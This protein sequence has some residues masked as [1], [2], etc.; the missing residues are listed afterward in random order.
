MTA[1]SPLSQEQVEVSI[2]EAT[3]L[4]QIGRYTQAVES[5]QRIQQVLQD[6]DF[7]G[8]VVPDVLQTIRDLLSEARSARAALIEQAREYLDAKHQTES[9][10]LA[11]L[12]LSEAND[13]LNRWKQ[14][15]VNEENQVPDEPGNL[16]PIYQA[17]LQRLEMRQH[18]QKIYE[19]VR[20][21][22]ESEWQ[23]AERLSQLE[24]ANVATSVLLEYYV[25]A[26]GYARD[27]A[28]K[29]PDNPL[30]GALA[31]K[32]EAHY[33]LIGRQEEAMTTA[34]MAHEFEKT[35]EYIEKVRDQ[36][37]WIQVFDVRGESQGRMPAERAYEYVTQQAREF[38]HQK[39]DEYLEEAKRHLADYAPREA[40]RILQQRSKFD[41][42]MTSDDRELLNQLESDVRKKVQ[43]LE[44]AEEV[45]ETAR[46]L[47]NTQDALA[48]WSKLHES[49]SQYEGAHALDRFQTVRE[50]ILQQA[51]RE[52][53][54]GQDDV[55]SLFERGRLADA[56]SRAAQLIARYKDVDLSLLKHVKALEVLKQ[57]VDERVSTKQAIHARL[58]AISQEAVSD[59]R[60]ASKQLE[61]LLHEHAESGLVPE[62]E[63]YADVQS[64][65]NVRLDAVGELDRLQQFLSSTDLEAVRSAIATAR[66]HAIEQTTHSQAFDRLANR[67]I[68]H[69]QYLMA[70][71]YR[72][73]HRYDKALDLLDSLANNPD[74]D[75]PDKLEEI[76]ALR[77]QIEER[78][79][80][81]EDNQQILEQ[82]EHFL[83]EERYDG[84]WSIL[85]TFEAL[86][87]EERLKVRK[88]QMQVKNEWRRHVDAQLRSLRIDREF[89][90]NWLNGL[91]SDLQQLDGQLYD[92]WQRDVGVFRLAQEARQYE[93]ANRYAD[94]LAKWQVVLEL[95]GSGMRTYIEERVSV[96]QRHA[97]QAEK[98]D[99][100]QRAN[101]ALGDPHQMQAVLD[102][103]VDFEQR[104]AALVNNS[105][106][107][108]T[109]QLEIIM[110]RAQCTAE[111][112]VSRGHFLRTRNLA[113]RLSSQ[114]SEIP[115]E[116]QAEAHTWIEVARRGDK[117]GEARVQLDASL[118]T[119]ASVGALIE[120]IQKW[121]A[122]REMH[123][124]LVFLNNWYQDRVQKVRQEL[125]QKV[126]N[127]PV[128]PDNLEFFA[129]LLILNPTDDLGSTILHQ[130]VRLQTAL[131]KDT[132][133]MVENLAARTAVAGATQGKRPADVLADQT[134]RL[135]TQHRYLETLYR[136]A[137]WLESTDML[138]DHAQRVRENCGASRAEL[139]LAIKDLEAMTSLVLDFQAYLDALRPSKDWHQE[140]D[141]GY[142]TEA[143]SQLTSL[144]AEVA[145]IRNNLQRHP[146]IDMLRSEF[147]QKQRSFDT[148]TRNL[149]EIYRRVSESAFDSELLRLVQAV[150]ET[151]LRRTFY[152]EYEVP[153]HYEGQRRMVTGWE[154]VV[155]FIETS[156]QKLSVVLD[157]A[158]PFGPPPD[159][160]GLPETP[161]VAIIN[162][163]VEKDDALKACQRAEFDEA[164]RIIQQAQEDSTPNRQVLTLREALETAQT[165]PRA[166]N[167]PSTRSTAALPVNE[168]YHEAFNHA[169]TLRGRRILE[170]MQTQADRY[171]RICQE[172][173]AEL[174]HVDDLEKQCANMIRE[175]ERA[176]QNVAAERERRRVR[177]DKL[178]KACQ[179]AHT[180][181]EAFRRT[182]PQ[183]PYLVA[184]V[185]E[186]S[187]VFRTCQGR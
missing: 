118:R 98:N 167:S 3:R 176:M 52:L 147:E 154:E 120:A 137:S 4:V 50:A 62:D 174:K 51:E 156:I 184:E 127:Q 43:A 38:A 116:H 139:E 11:A 124:A 45:A 70:R 149:R 172:A 186:N 104:L 46:L 13:F 171:Q 89:D 59:L 32:A 111:A 67:L 123:T 80:E 180:Q 16:L 68:L 107:Y 163:A 105:P 117:I 36:N 71:E 148:L 108:G 96:L 63:L 88:L 66:R 74:L 20:E 144:Q 183:H 181:L 157:W 138:P 73:M 136:T 133:E 100:V 44:R 103:L 28:S 10:E 82:A 177:R 81:R 9:R 84:A 22:V 106:L 15:V 161:P 25:R 109:W 126:H 131:S 17:K 128:Q 57:Q 121:E 182:Y 12:D 55:T 76:I 146:A 169:G 162:W 140:P 42:F 21:Q 31:E 47:L 61:R 129:K 6:E 119:G 150:D 152:Y 19:Q 145:R 158:Q 54:Q 102:E 85:D 37:V 187:S 30:L 179:N 160:T 5:L 173:E 164:R 97:F 90:F 170:W 69:E 101:T 27:M 142:W 34:V 14:A 75:D 60:A 72:D 175:L 132:R 24:E 95:A 153:D 130:I 110:I 56:S 168:R 113:T 49:L 115:A 93:A 53:Q 185:W 91:L 134:V 99:I 8:G 125:Q 39:A 2:Q 77:E 41:R 151:L 48:A 40:L 83:Q 135:K 87:S 141:R 35:F 155:S 159:V 114:V 64:S 29:Y 79:R 166:N 1:Q 122:E 58:Q 86:T 94:A 178:D 143:M 23:E 92:R 78:F 165:P 33:E 26:H 65:I 18:Q 7:N 112:E